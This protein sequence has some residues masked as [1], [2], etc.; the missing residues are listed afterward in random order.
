MGDLCRAVLDTNVIVS[1]GRSQSGKSPNREILSRIR[2][3][4]IL[5][6][7]STGT[8]YEYEKKLSERGVSPI[9]TA[10]ILRLIVELGEDV[11]IKTM[12]VRAYPKDMLDVEFVLC[13]VNG[14]ASHLVSYDHHLLDLDSDY[15]F[16]ICKP[17]P[18][19]EEIR[20]S[21]GEKEAP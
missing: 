9:E 16:R 1:A 7:F 18:F 20:A 3:G 4:Q 21:R 14:A 5:P 19:L 8:L 10:K 17:V 11:W 6:L 12:H 13:A 15:P 2:E